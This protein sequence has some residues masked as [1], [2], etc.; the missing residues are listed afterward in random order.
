MHPKDRRTPKA[1]NCTQQVCAATEQQHFPFFGSLVEVEASSSS[2]CLNPSTFTENG[3]MTTMC[4]QLYATNT[5]S[6]FL[7]STRNTGYSAGASSYFCYYDL[8]SNGVETVE[9]CALKFPV[10]ALPFIVQLSCL[11]ANKQNHTFYQVNTSTL[12]QLALKVISLPQRPSTWP[13]AVDQILTWRTSLAS[14][15]AQTGKV[16]A[17]TLL[18]RRY[19]RA[20][21]TFHPPFL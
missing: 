10:G 2:V 14:N 13:T 4:Y 8:N 6:G 15:V 16:F 1:I 11:V 3:I 18:A 9:D 7:S 5:E 21:E 17:T 12:H 20:K 19:V